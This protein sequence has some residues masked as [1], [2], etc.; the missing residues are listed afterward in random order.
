MTFP[1]YPVKTVNEMAAGDA[2][3][4]GKIVPLGF[5]ADKGVTGAAVVESLAELQG[6]S[7]LLPDEFAGGYS[8]AFF[9]SNAIILLSI[10]VGNEN[11]DHQIDGLVRAGDALCVGTTVVWVGDPIKPMTIRGSRRFAFEVSKAAVVGVDG[12]ERFTFD[13]KDA[14][15]LE[16]MPPNLPEPTIDDNFKDDMVSVIIKRA[17]STI[18]GV[19]TP[20][21]F[22]GVDVE[23]VYDRTFLDEAMLIANDKSFED[24]FSNEVFSQILSLKLTT[25]CKESVLSAIAVLKMLDIVFWADPCFN[26]EISTD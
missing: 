19:Y 2:V 12:V 13:W 16:S 25:K 22:T 7:G 1:Q 3:G 17:H 8:E 26:Y 24:V 21:D 15:F 20:D 5:Y 9:G 18:N 6:Y 14:A 23:S 10:R 11:I 4:I